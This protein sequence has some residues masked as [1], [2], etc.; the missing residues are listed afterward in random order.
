MFFSWFL[1]RIHYPV[2][3]LCLGNGLTPTVWMGNNSSLRRCVFSPYAFITNYHLW[4]I[5]KIYLMEK[6]PTFLQKKIRKID[7]E[8]PQRFRPAASVVPP[9]RPV[10]VKAPG[11]LE[12][13]LTS[14]FSF[15]GPFDLADGVFMFSLFFSSQSSSS[16]WSRNSGRCPCKRY[17]YCKTHAL[18]DHKHTKSHVT[19]LKSGH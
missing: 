19:L 13:N 12:W 8:P 7:T 16:N 3:R 18:T 14:R 1:C 11:K 5:I 2:S 9:R 6:H 17:W 15:S 10:A 4:I